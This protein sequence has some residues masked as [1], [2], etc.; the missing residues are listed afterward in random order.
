MLAS[1]LAAGFFM[2]AIVRRKKYSGKENGSQSMG[3]VDDGTRHIPA[4]R[5]EKTV[6]DRLGASGPEM[7][8]LLHNHHGYQRNKASMGWSLMV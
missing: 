7:I 4:T 6:L 5:R 2:T 3:R 8:L 1:P